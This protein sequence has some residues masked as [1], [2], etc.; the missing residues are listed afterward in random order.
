M[1]AGLAVEGLAKEFAV[2]RTRVAAIRGVSF[3]VEEG[4]FY[5]LL[6]PSGCGKTTTLR[7]VAGS[8]QLSRATAVEFSAVRHRFSDFRC[9]T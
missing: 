2:D 4:A 8:R 3:T 5:T 6:G 7:C 1:T 9:W